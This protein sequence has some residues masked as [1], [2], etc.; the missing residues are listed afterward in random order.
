MHRNA[1]MTPAG[2]LRLCRRIEDGCPVA[3]AASSM[4]ISS[5][6]GPFLVAS[7]RRHSSLDY[8]TPD[9]FEAVSS[10]KN[11]IRTLI[12]EVFLTLPRKSRRK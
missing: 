3:H 1:P 6:S 11:Q 7:L 12:T 4:G 5:Q 8:L 2:R 9:E 10:E